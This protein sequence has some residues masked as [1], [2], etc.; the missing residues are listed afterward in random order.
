MGNDPNGNIYIGDS[1]VIN[2]SGD[3]IWQKNKEIVCS[4]ISLDKSFLINYR[5]AFP[6]YLDK[7]EFEIKNY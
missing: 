1:S 4:T 3:I 7:D 2:P 6:F 5:N